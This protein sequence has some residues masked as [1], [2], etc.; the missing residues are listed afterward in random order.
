MIDP[1]GYRQLFI[2]A[3]IEH[4]SHLCIPL[5]T[6]EVRMI[7]ERDAA[8]L[9]FQNELAH[10]RGSG[11]VAETVAKICIEGEEGL[12][13]IRIDIAGRQGPFG[14]TPVFVGDGGGRACGNCR[15]GGGS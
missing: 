5:F 4:V 13:V 6:I 8:S 3:S 10:D 2:V 12:S 11:G 14:R 7:R 9:Q 15:W 1:E